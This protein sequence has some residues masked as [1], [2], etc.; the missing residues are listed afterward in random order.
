MTEQ[1]PLR[2]GAPPSLTVRDK[3]YARQL[4]EDGVSVKDVAKYMGVSVATLMRGL[5]ELRA[6]LGPEKFRANGH[7]ARSFVRTRTLPESQVR[8]SETR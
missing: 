2:R 3:F 6:K 1:T 7:R 5:A 4:R 8:T